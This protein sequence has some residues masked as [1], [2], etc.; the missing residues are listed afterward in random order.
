VSGEP[1]GRK[2]RIGI[3]NLDLV[4]GLAGKPD[5]ELAEI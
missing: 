4:A 5:E 1:V 3:A 2:I